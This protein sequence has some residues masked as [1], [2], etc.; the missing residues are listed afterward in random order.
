MA[1]GESMGRSAGNRPRASARRRNSD[2]ERAQIT[3]LIDDP[4]AWPDEQRLSP[5]KTWVHN[6]AV[7]GVA[8]IYIM[9]WVCIAGF[10]S[11]WTARIAYGFIVSSFVTVSLGCYAPAKR[12]RK[13]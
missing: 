6:A 5:I 7:A 13:H 3:H 2:E 11:G 8:F 4:E 1:L 12:D 9:T 10:A